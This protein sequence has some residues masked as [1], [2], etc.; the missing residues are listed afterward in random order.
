[1][2]AI[3]VAAF[4]FLFNSFWFKISKYKQCCL[5]QSMHFRIKYSAKNNKKTVHNS[6]YGQSVTIIIVSLWRLIL[7]SEFWLVYRTKKLWFNKCKLAAV[8]PR[9]YKMILRKLLES[10][11]GP[12][13]FQCIAI[14]FSVLVHMHFV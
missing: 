11:G 2:L 5:S 4:L 6:K 12:T 1:M 10:N 9:G 14:S 7:F 8:F 13:H 3:N